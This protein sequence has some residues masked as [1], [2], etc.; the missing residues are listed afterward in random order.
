MVALDG[1]LQ[2]AAS[3]ATRAAAAHAD[4]AADP[5]GGAIVSAA[6]GLARNGRLRHERRVV[7][8]GWRGASTLRRA[9]SRHVETRFTSDV[10]HR[11]ALLDA[12][13]PWRQLGAAA[14]RGVGVL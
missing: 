7:P 13:A 11:L 4:L 2:C 3:A 9:F 1:G 8:D 6:D 12:G 5:A 10:Q 14:W